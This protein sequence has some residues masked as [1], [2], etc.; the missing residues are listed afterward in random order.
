MYA[1]WDEANMRFVAKNINSISIFECKSSPSIWSLIDGF[2]ENS[3]QVIS[4]LVT[5]EIK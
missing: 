4:A 1:T 2:D 3:E 5:W